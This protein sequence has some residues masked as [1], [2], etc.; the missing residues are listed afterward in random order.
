VR[1]RNIL[2]KSIAIGVAIIWALPFIGIVMTAL[3]PSREVLYGWWY[4]PFHLSIKNFVGAWTHPTAALG[5]GLRNS[6]QVAVGATVLPTL[7][8]SLMAYGLG[9]LRFP[10]RGPLLMLIGL[11]LALP[12][13][14]IAWPLFREMHAMGLLNS[15]TGLILA[16]SAW[17]LPWIVFFLRGYIETLPVELEEAARIDGAGRLKTFLYVIFPLMLPALASVMV[18]QFTWVWNDFFLALILIFDPNKM[19]LT[20][21]IPLLRGQYHVDWGLLSAGALITMLVP[22][23]V[24]IFLQRYFVKGLIG[25]AVK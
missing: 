16:H 20:Q 25:G 11:L 24:F 2:A 5:I 18:L 21:R 3:R 14:M 1:K 7:V 9:R 22:L 12:Q 13:Q 23:L 17:G 10:G 15:L 8:A 6:V 19:V 4:P